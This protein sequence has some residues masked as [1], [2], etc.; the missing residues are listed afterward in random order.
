MAAWERW[1]I[2]LTPLAAVTTMA[3]GLRLG[4][5]PA[6]HAAIVYG[7]PPVKAEGGA[8]RFAW[9]V[10]TLVDDRG[11]R[12]SVPMKGLTFE[13]TI[14][15]AD[16]QDGAALRTADIAT[17]AD[18]VAEVTFTLPGSAGEPLE[19]R[20]TAEGESAPLA[21]GLVTW[22][23]S[24]EREVPAGPA[25]A[26]PSK[27]DGDL[28]VEVAVYG[29]RMAPGAGSS[30]W[31]HVRDR[32]S[33][34]DVASATI[35]ADPEPGLDLASSRVTT[36]GAGWAELRA[37]AQIHVVA[38]G[39]KVETPSG[40]LLRHGGWYGALPV[41]P[42]AAIARVPRTVEAHKS[43]DIDVLVPTVAPRLY[44]EIDD[45][46]GRAFADIVD[47]QRA[48]LGAHATVHVDGR[49]APGT[50]WFVTSS[51]P[52]GAESLTD[53]ALALPFLAVASPG[54]MEPDL[55]AR[56][57]TIAPPSFARFVALDGLPGRRKADG[58]RRRKGF[59]LAFGSLAVAAAL[60][61][62]LILRGVERT[63][64]DLA[65]VTEQLEDHASVERRFS[66][67]SGVIG[68]LIALLGFALLAA[69]LT[70]KAG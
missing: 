22:P 19:L 15:R 25:F 5:A 21:A 1:A 24:V 28:L 46:S 31:V 61:T 60:E 16:G 20:V 66:A 70:W 67:A 36:D 34:D 58:G 48:D 59:L 40:G 62:L 11:V 47:V 39:L 12:E 9:Q 69:L 6:V 2:V 52:R 14:H 65:R 51:E 17:N 29:G 55:G 41:A 45:A 56:L 10:L 4:A 30:V 38:L 68:L 23:S 37:T 13:A 8:W 64:R 32:G 49:L 3:A 42:G 43:F 26:R 35:E 57:A 53:G 18:G 33:R 7:A 50:C 44:V 63:R 54:P 27:Q